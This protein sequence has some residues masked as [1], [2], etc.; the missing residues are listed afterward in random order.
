MA[1]LVDESNNVSFAQMFVFSTKSVKLRL[2]CVT[3]S[4]NSFFAGVLL[5]RSPRTIC[6]LFNCV[7]LRLIY[8]QQQFMLDVLGMGS[9]SFG[10]TRVVYRL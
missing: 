7:T 5:Y 9:V 6:S 2:D 3:Q 4:P 8:A 1:E 10:K